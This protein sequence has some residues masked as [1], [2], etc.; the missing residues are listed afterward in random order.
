MCWPH[1]WEGEREEGSC[2]G[3]REKKPEGELA[4]AVIG[5]Q[6]MGRLSVTQLSLE[7]SR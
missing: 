1:S 3:D 2:R 6:N 5:P 7:S 4:A